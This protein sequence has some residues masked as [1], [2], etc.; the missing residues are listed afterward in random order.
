M[1]TLSLSELPVCHIKYIS[2][3][4]A[5]SMLQSFNSEHYRF[6]HSVVWIPLYSLASIMHTWYTH[7]WGLD[8]PSFMAIPTLLLSSSPQDINEILCCVNK[9]MVLF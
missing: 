4:L 5:R 9:K 3:L 7:Q 2:L 1:L 6:V 8:H